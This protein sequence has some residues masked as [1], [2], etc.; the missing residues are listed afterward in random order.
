M[1]KHRGNGVALGSIPCGKCFWR[2]WAL[3]RTFNRL[4]VMPSIMAT[5]NHVVTALDIRFALELPICSAASLSI[6]R[7]RCCAA[8]AHPP[9]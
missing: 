8:H 7:A 4:H 6:P 2:D 9:L 5:S 3:R 1:V